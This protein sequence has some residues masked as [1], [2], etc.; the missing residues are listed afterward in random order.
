MSADSAP[1]KALAVIASQNSCVLATIGP[2][3]PYT[4]LMAYA[5]FDGGR[6]LILVMEK[7][8]TKHR[9]LKQDPRVSIL[10]DTRASGADRDLIVALT[11]AGEACLDADQEVL[12]E[13]FEK[14]HPGFPLSGRPNSV[15]VPITISSILMLNGPEKAQ[16]FPL[17]Q[18]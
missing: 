1:E 9:N 8:S 4:S 11:L 10:V 13:I 16:F 17:V 5:Q 18:P 6:R 15:F 2:E 12:A 3:G 14:S 7:D